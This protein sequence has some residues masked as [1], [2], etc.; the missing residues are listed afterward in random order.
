MH[1]KYFDHEQRGEFRGDFSRDTYDLRNHFTRVLMQQGRVQLDADWNEQVSILLR[2]LRALAEDLIGPHGGPKHNCGFEIIP[3]STNDFNIGRGH[4]YV[5]GILGENEEQLPYTAQWDYPLPDDKKLQN[6]QTYLVYLDVWERHIT[7]IQDDSI[8]EV[9]LG[10][11]DTA[12]RAKLVWQ[13]KTYPLD[14]V[15]NCDNVPWDELLKKRQP[16]NRGK[17]KAR[18]KLTEDIDSTDPCITPPEAR[19][20]GAENQLYRVEIHRSGNVC[21]G[22][23]SNKAAAATFKWSRENGSVIFPIRSMAIT[24]DTTTVTLEHLGRDSRFSLQEGDWVEIVDD[25]YVL[26]G[27]DESLLKVSSVDRV[28]MQVTLEGTPGSQV[29]QD[30][31]KHPLL[32][33]WDHKA[34]D[35]SGGGLELHDGAAIIK[36]GLDDNAWLYL[37]DGVQIQFHSGAVYCTGDYWLIPSR[38]ATGDVE[39]PNEKDN[40]GNL[41][42]EALPP[43]GVIHHYAPLAIISV[44]DGNVDLLNDCR[45]R[46]N[47]L[48][49]RPFYGYGLGSIGIGAHLI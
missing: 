30:P 18:A 45:C 17:L 15:I 10:G 48:C 24:T 31:T 20:R 43:H 42:P 26:Q 41:I 19:Y 6:D 14:N 2:Y 34:G 38:T 36:K 25:D 8:R 35:P 47:P 4:Y 46:F 13:V 7:Y 44:T 29:G 11:P 37:E 1:D 39:W 3:S 21:D 33:R 49:F 40:Q 28:K 32:R 16:E 22:D 5:N 12:T 27:R 9:A 23:E